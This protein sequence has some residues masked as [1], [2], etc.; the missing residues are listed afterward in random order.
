MNRQ[1]IADDLLPVVSFADILVFESMHGVSINAQWTDHLLAQVKRPVIDVYGFRE[2]AFADWLPLAEALQ[3]QLIDKHAVAAEVGFREQTFV[4][5]ENPQADVRFAVNLSP[6]KYN[7][8]ILCLT[9]DEAYVCTSQLLL[10]DEMYRMKG[11][12]GV[13]T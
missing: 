11:P 13:I 6:G 1:M 3:Q 4:F 12:L 5:L 9:S 2:I 10:F 8:N 7:G